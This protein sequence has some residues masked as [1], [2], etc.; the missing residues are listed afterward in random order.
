MEDEATRTRR[1]TAGYALALL[2]TVVWSGNF[3]VVRG[4]SDALSPVSL[5]FW[6]WVVAIAVLAPFS[7]RG[8]REDWPALR[9]HGRY[10]ALTSLLGVSVFNTAIYVAGRTVAAVD[11]SII[12]ASSPVFVI[13]LTRVFHREPLGSGRLAGVALSLGGVIW[14]VTDGQPEHLLHL[15]LGSGDLVMLGAALSFAGYTLLVR[16]RPAGVRLQSF[17]LS[18]F[19]LGLVFLT[20]IYLWSAWD[21]PAR[22]PDTPVLLAILYVGVFA[23]VVAYLA[24]NAAIA[25]IGP[26]RA[27]VVYY[28]IP[29]FSGLGGWLLLDEPISAAD[30]VSAILI[31]AGIVMANRQGREMRRC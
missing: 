24:W 31:V 18:S 7:W 22:I 2:A 5:A 6:R 15:A 25:R 10:L 3:L 14:L 8:L 27:A 30:A 20:P 19:V 13:L 26:S 16:Q 4:L 21:L 1:A 11:L 29:V 9:A 23:S 12:A 17:A 28:A